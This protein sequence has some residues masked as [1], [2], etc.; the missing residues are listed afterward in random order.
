MSHLGLPNPPLI[1]EH[2]VA[3][4]LPG[5]TPA[6]LISN[7]ARADQQVARGTLRQLPTLAADCE[8]G[9]PTLTVIGHVVNL[10]ADT[11]LHFPASL[12]P[13]REAVAV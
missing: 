8:A 2:L 12:A 10:F 6:A 9:V 3:A 7:G 4:G 1:A 13:A 11:A 5:D